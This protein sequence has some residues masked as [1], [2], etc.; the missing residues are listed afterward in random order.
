MQRNISS[1][2]ILVFVILFLILPV[3]INAQ[4]VDKKAMPVG[5]IK[6]LYENVKYPE[7]AK[8][9]NIQGKVLLEI[10][11]NKDGK[12]DEIKV[13]ETVSDDL[14]KAAVDAV[15]KTSFIPAVKDGKKVN[16]VINI[17]FIFK[18]DSEKSDK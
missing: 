15:K 7:S 4:K 11:I 6:A 12:P 18:L 3:S 10:T 8:K 16:T 17:P 13:K 14:A 9:E 2:L 1:K 5:G